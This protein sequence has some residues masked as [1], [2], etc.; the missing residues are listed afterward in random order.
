[1]G[2]YNPLYNLNNQSFFIAHMYVFNDP[3]LDKTSTSE[4][5]PSYLLPP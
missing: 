2:E 3:W 5:S 4:T 1:M